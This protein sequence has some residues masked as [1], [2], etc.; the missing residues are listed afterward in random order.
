MTLS[1]DQSQIAEEQREEA[2]PGDEDFREALAKSLYEYA[3]RLVDEHPWEV[4]FE[5]TKEGFYAD[6]DQIRQLMIDYGLAPSPGGRRYW[7][8][9]GYGD[10]AAW[11]AQGNDLNLRA[12]DALSIVYESLKTRPGKCPSFSSYDR[13]F[14]DGAYDW[15]D[16]KEGDSE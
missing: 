4:A 10:G 15:T 1:K 16:S 3:T 7:Y 9:L 13:G 11:A 5:S 8:E 14:R 2:L 6:A 12:G